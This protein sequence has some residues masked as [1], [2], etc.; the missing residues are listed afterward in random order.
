MADD[1]TP[2]RRLCQGCARILIRSVP[3]G[4]T[5]YRMA[6]GDKGLKPAE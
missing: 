2:G 3:S 4:A 1:R 5:L 6:S